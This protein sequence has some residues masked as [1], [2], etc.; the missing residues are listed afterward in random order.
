MKIT[1]ISSI[2]EKLFE[3]EDIK[4]DV[5]EAWQIKN[6]EIHLLLL[7]SQDRTWLRLLTPIA[8]ASEAQSLLPQILED[9]FEATGEARYA[10]NQNVLW[11][12]YHHRLETL[13]AEDL[14]SA[15]ASLSSLA[16]KGLSSSFNKLIEKQ[17]IQIVKAA[18]A[19][20][21]S[22]EATYQTIDRFYQEGVMGGLDGDP[23]QRKQFLA[24][25]KMQLDR[26]WS[27]VEV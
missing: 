14:E 18:K 2:L 20:G 17:I 3:T 26:L 23:A 19:Q 11:G 1:E 16:E 21:Q 12:V 6:S 8:T 5:E 25:W 4:H 27:E 7:L 13:V 15:I 24:A 9:N 10:I 22:L